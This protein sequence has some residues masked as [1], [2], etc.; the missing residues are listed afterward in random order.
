MVL[1]SVSV[2]D[3]VEGAVEDGEEAPLNLPEGET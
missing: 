1:L 3:R 2:L